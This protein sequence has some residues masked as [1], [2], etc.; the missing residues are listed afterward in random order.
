MYLTPTAEV[1]ELGRGR[2]RHVQHLKPVA[3]EDHGLRAIDSR[4]RDSGLPG[5]PHL[6]TASK[7]MTSVADD[8]M[9]RLH[10][11]REAERYLEVGAPY[12]RVGV[13]EIRATVHM[14]S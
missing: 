12:V 3:Y 13:V 8:G 4:W 6:V 10:P 11:T 5:L 1:E 2:Y 14:G 7:L 9:R